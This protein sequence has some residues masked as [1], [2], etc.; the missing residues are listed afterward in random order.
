MTISSIGI[1][2]VGNPLRKDDGIG[3]LLLDQ[4]KKESDP[5]PHNVSFVDGGTG[6]MNLLH[7]F[8]RFDLIIL[9][10]AVNFQ[11][12]PGE[13]RFFSLND[14]KSQKQVS[15]V[16]T[17]NADL[18]QIIRL[19]QEL[20]ECPKKIFVFGVQPA[21]VSF[22]EGLTEAVQNKFNDIRSSMKNHVFRIVEDQKRK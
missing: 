5:L 17:H 21:D 9:L 7:L 16:S 8:N 15:T 2:G 12:S 4:L 1:I 3:I 20:N 14:I 19:G 18:F 22:G 11:G 13:T 6:G 10:D